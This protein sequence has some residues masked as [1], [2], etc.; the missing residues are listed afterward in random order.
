[1]TRIAINSMALVEKLPP[2]D[3]RWG[4]FNDSFQNKELPAVDIANAIYCGHAYTTWHKGRRSVDNFLCGQHIAVDLE[5]GDKRST[6]DYLRHQDFVAI[7]ASLLY[8]T[9][10][11]TEENPR[12]RA[13]FLL[14]T[15]IEDAA[16]YKAATAFV[17]SL[18]D[19]ADTSCVDA[20]RF[21]YGSRDC[22]IEYLD[23][24]LPLAQLRNYYRH[25]HKPATTKKQAQPAVKQAAPVEKVVEWAIQDAPGEGRNNR[26]YRLGRQLFELGLAQYEAE[27]V[28]RQYQQ[29][30]Q[31]LKPQP[32]TEQEALTNLRSA[33]M[34]GV[35]H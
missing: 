12:C 13:V 9:P 10:S 1:M 28:M 25:Y 19:G 2:G 7:Y 33:Y 30:V 26:G 17:Y 14:D 11:H 23:N 22:Q 18:F 31:N 35:T 15:P 34:R 16:A 3:Y 8:T 29:A 27:G 6:L 24:V 20:S 32:Y 4:Q 5:T 21:F